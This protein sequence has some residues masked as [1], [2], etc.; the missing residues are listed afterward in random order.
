MRFHN[1]FSSFPQISAKYTTNK[2]WNYNN[3]DIPGPFLNSNKPWTGPMWHSI[4]ELVHLV[5]YPRLIIIGVISIFSDALKKSEPFLYI[6]L[7]DYRV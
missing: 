5:P 6:H 2:E 1:I 7:W 3:Q 4:L